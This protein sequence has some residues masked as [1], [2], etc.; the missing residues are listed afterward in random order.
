MSL[1]DRLWI[2]HTRKIVMHSFFRKLRQFTYVVGLA[3]FLVGC[4]D[5]IGLS[6]DDTGDTAS[7]PEVGAAS[8][9]VPVE[10]RR[11]AIVHSQTSKENFYD[12]FAYNQLFASVQHQSMMAGLPFD[13]LD[14]QQL[15]VTANLTDYDVIIIPAF[16]NVKS[17]NQ[18]TDSGFQ[19]Q[20]ETLPFQ[21]PQRR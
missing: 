7:A 10:R 12:P 11:V 2:I 3:L 4:L 15:A 13:L 5:S 17:S 16:A 14:E 1:F 20:T 21:G 8:V 6:V 19:Q 9:S 18:T